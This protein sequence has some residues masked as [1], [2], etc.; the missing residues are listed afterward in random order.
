VLSSRLANESSRRAFSPAAWAGVA[1]FL[2]IT[3]VLTWLPALLLR[4]V[5]RGLSGTLPVRLWWSALLYAVTMGWQPLIAALIV[6]RWFDTSE[7]LDHGVRPAPRGYAIAA[8]IAPLVLL[9]ASTLIVV[10][11]GHATLGFGTPAPAAT[12]ALLPAT[13]LPALAIV[14]LQC[15]GEEI[16]WRG[17][18]L[19]RLMRELGPWTGL[20]VHGVVWGIWYA[21][22][23]LVVTTASS[24]QAGSA[25]RAAE[26]V[27]TCTLLG[28]LLG[29]VRLASKSIMTAV[30][31]NA[32]LTVAAGLPFVLRNVDVGPLGA[33]WGPAGWLPLAL[34]AGVLLFGR[35]RTAIRVPEARRRGRAHTPVDEVTQFQDPRWLN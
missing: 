32:I 33:V 31:A 18:F 30:I 8:A 21:P 1:V 24:A 35:G 6:R 25:L 14:Y 9:V 3:F 22:A 13:L 34:A 23:F 5:T 17:Y 16:G 11:A 12:L 15:I 27:L 2:A 26:F 7:G 28:A 19:A 4:P 10:G 29:W 20:L